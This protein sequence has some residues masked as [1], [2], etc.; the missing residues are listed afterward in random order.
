MLPNLDQERH[1]NFSFWYRIRGFGARSG[2]RRFGH[3]VTCVDIDKAKLKGLREGEIPIFE[4]GLEAIVKS[5][6]A[7]GRLVFSSDAASAIAGAQV[8]FIAVGNTA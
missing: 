3:H 5:A 6:Y 2:T 8:H 4:P 1:E 7:A